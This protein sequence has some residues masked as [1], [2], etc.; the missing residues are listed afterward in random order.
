MP[1]DNQTI[2]VPAGDSRRIVIPVKDADGGDAK[3]SGATIK[4][5]MAPSAYA[6]GDEVLL[7]KQTGA[8]IT[9]AGSTATVAVVPADTDTIT[10]GTYYHET[11]VAFADGN[12]ST[13]SR[14]P[15]VIEP[16][17]IR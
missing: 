5:W 10:P 3:L 15:F 8:G 12:V 14:G 17:I 9:V 16:T 1:A 2:T 6:S 7:K 4:W 13:V 11:E